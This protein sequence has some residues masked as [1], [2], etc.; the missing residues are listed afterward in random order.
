MRFPLVS[1]EVVADGL[2]VVFVAGVAAF[3]KKTGFDVIERVYFAWKYR[4]DANGKARVN[5]GCIGFSGFWRGLHG[6]SFGG[7]KNSATKS[8]SVPPKGAL[9]QG[10]KQC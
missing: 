7:V 5:A 2:H 1:C 8:A 10:V 6:V 4:N 3:N 9:L